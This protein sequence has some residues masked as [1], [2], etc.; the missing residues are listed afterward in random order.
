MAS[1]TD[2][3]RWRAARPPQPPPQAGPRPHVARA[4]EPAQL[5]QQPPEG[6]TRVWPRRQ[7]HPRRPPLLPP[8]DR[9]GAI[10]RRCRSM[11][12]PIHRDRRWAWLLTDQDSGRLQEPGCLLRDCL[13]LNSPPSPSPTPPLHAAVIRTN[14]RLC[15]RPTFC[16]AHQTMPKYFRKK[17]PKSDVQSRNFAQNM[18][19]GPS[20]TEPNTDTQNLVRLIIG[21]CFG[22]N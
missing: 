8:P 20:T 6:H 11:S 5:P 13:H 18:D 22:P 15:H 1:H 14:R 16:S 4:P 17:V 12:F 9:A 7:P 19:R 21:Q 10:L 3:C 2:H